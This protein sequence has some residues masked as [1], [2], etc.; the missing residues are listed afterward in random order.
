[1]C[2]EEWQAWLKQNHAHAKVAWLVYHNTRSD[3]CSIDYESSVLW[4]DRQYY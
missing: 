1:M 2:G 4:L 3:D